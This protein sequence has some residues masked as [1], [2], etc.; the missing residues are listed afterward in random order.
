MKIDDITESSLINIK[1]LFVEIYLICR[2]IQISPEFQKNKIDEYTLDENIVYNWRIVRQNIIFEILS[3]TPLK[4]N[5][6]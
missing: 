2:H 1:H 3:K 4:V 5:Y 6:I